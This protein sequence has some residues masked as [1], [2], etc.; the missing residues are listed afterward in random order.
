MSN[1]DIT[2]MQFELTGY[3]TVE[4]EADQVEKSHT[5]HPADF[6][7][8]E[9][10]YYTDAEGLGY[11]ATLQ[12]SGRDDAGFELHLQLK[13]HVT[14]FHKLEWAYAFDGEVVDDQLS[15]VFEPIEGKD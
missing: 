2:Q 10:G 13:C 6:A 14:Q 8:R 9:G 5:F 11:S 15:Y 4:Y 3:I 7:L 12:A 1:S